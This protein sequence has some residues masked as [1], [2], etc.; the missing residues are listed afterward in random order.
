MRTIRR[1][2]RL[3]TV[4]AVLGAAA[5]AGCADRIVGPGQPPPPQPGRLSVQ[6]TTPNT[7]D[8]AIMFRLTGPT[9]MTDVQEARPVYVSHHRESASGITVAVFGALESGALLTFS[10]PDVRRA[11]EYVVTVHEVADDSNALRDDLT[12]YSAVVRR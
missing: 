1:T 7:G 11:A 10:V 8:A 2:V 6:L 4:A 9:T 5:S 3:V 12:G